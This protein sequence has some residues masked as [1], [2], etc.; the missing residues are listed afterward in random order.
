MIEDRGGFLSR[1]ELQGYNLRNDMEERHWECPEMSFFMSIAYNGLVMP[2]CHMR[3]D[4]PNHQD[5]IL[6]D[7]NKQTIAEILQSKKYQ[8]LKK[9]LQ[10]PKSNGI[11]GICTY[12]QKIRNCNLKGGADN[13]TYIYPEE[14]KII[15]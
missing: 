12:C 11:P 1:E 7:L 14:R 8:E 5:Y 10:E 13:Y 2:C 15:G 6:G 4:N 3:F 9:I